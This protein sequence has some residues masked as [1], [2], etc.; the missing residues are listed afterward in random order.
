MSD[1]GFKSPFVKLLSL[2]PSGFNANIELDFDYHSV[3][4]SGSVS[5]L[6]GKEQLFD[7]FGLMTVEE[8]A[9]LLHKQPQTIRNMVARRKIPFLKLGRKS[10]FRREALEAWIK[11][12]EFN[13]WQ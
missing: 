4:S 9:T 10:M 5:A 3:A 8:V 6:K 11:Q 7:S 12:K 2:K 13:P 1:L